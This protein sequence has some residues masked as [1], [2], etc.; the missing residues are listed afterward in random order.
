MP[1]SSGELSYLDESS[2]RERS[3]SGGKASALADLAA[4]G[5]PIVNGFV[6]HA[7]D[8]P[9]DALR[10]EIAAA[11][12]A[13]GSSAFAVRSSATA[14][15]LEGASF[16]GVYDSYLNVRGINE[17][18]ARAEDVRA[19]LTSPRARAYAERLGIDPDAQ[20][21]AVLVQPLLDA[22]A[23]GVAFTRDPLTGASDRIVINAVLGLGEGVV[24]G[25]GEADHYVTDTTATNILERTIATKRTRVIA[26]AGGGIAT[27][28]VDADDA[29]RPA[30]S[31][32]EVLAV[33]T[34]ARRVRDAVG[35]RDLEFAIVEGVA[36]LLQARPITGLDSPQD[37]DEPP[38][39]V[40]WE[41]P[42]DAAYS[43]RLASRGPVPV[44]Q[45]E[46][47]DRYD[48]N[49]ARVFEDTGVM[50]A[51]AHIARWVNGYRYARPV[52]VDQAEIERRVNRHQS[53]N[54]ELRAQGGSIWL[55]D[56]ESRTVE[57][58][59]RLNRYTALR[60]RG[61]DERL[62]HL[63]DA[64]D[65]FGLV[66]GDLHWRMAGASKHDWPSSYERITDEPQVDAGVL[67]QA[68]DNRTTRLI[69]RVRGLA[70]IAQSDAMLGPAL[71]HRDYALIL[72]ASGPNGGGSEKGS[73]V[74]LQVPPAP[75]RL[76]HAYGRRL[77]LERA[78]GRANVE[79]GTGAAA[80]PRAVLRR[81]GHRRA[82]GAGAH[83]PRPA[84]C[85]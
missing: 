61:I 72:D 62:A 71:E 79:H 30:L 67:L 73:A 5:L 8:Q 49:S 48:Q 78:R 31:D 23:A 14:E 60:H 3:L 18:L 66:M 1:G 44:L 70:A 13:T 26:A 4:D 53:H 52:E 6:I 59:Q 42:E 12:A 36:H 54:A 20:Q 19:S 35:D 68:L 50:M 2:A 38:F 22:S 77:R 29:E 34:L 46:G 82:R 43:W 56:V 69:R 85:G 33:A 63:E 27:V 45:R 39:P 17:V 28:E 84:G 55:S 32:D 9:L 11:L 40:E 74:P 25:T 10:E 81:T 76:R 64:L 7:G 15:D 41:N 80:R 58:W 57:V 51:R 83:R 65:G 75:R 16:A 37:G 47:R 24:A 21:M